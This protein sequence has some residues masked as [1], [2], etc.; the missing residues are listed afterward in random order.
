MQDIKQ[1]QR[2]EQKPQRSLEQY[3]FLPY[4]D[5]KSVRKRIA[6]DYLPVTH[7][8]G[9]WRNVMWVAGGET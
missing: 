2:Q 9:W 5:K 6:S 1:S 4:D 7:V 8:G 3:P